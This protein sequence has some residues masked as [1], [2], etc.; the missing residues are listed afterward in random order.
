MNI[1]GAYCQASLG[2]LVTSELVRDTVSMHQIRSWSPRNEVWVVLWP[3]H[4]HASTHTH[5]G[6]CVQRK[7]LSRVWLNGSV[8][9]W[10]RGVWNAERME[11]NLRAEDL[12][13]LFCGRGSQVCRSGLLSRAETVLLV[14]SPLNSLSCLRARRK[15]GAMQMQSCFHVPN[16][17]QICAA[18]EFVQPCE[19]LTVFLC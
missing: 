8:V 3:P 16:T 18:G 5:T 6:T 11:S 14:R 4:A 15:D 19:F 7:G 12:G 1:H 17:S 9:A 13:G 2:Y 10:N